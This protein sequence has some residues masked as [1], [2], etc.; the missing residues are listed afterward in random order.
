MVGEID[1]MFGDEFGFQFL[2]VEYKFVFDGDE[3]FFE[4]RIVKMKSMFE[5]IM[6]E[7]VIVVEKY[8]VVDEDG[9]V[10]EESYKI[11]EDGKEVI[12]DREKLL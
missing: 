3:V 1:V 4:I 8:R 11:I 7:F 12:E 6:E 9:N 5:L 10:I 2:C